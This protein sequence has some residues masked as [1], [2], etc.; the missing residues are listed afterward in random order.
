MQKSNTDVKLD[1]KV[2][3]ESDEIRQACQEAWQIIAPL[4]PLR[5]VIAR[6]PLS[7]LEHMRFEKAVEWAQAHFQK[8]DIAQPLEVINRESIKWFQA[9][10]DA[11]QATITMPKRELGLFHS[12]KLLARYDTHLHQHDPERIAWLQTLPN[13][14][15]FALSRCLHK[16]GITKELYRDFFILLLTTLPGWAGY[17]QYLVAWPDPMQVALF[18][19]S[20]MDFL[21][22]RVVMTSLFWTDCVDYLTKKP[23]DDHVS[24][25]FQLSQTLHKIQHAEDSYRDTLIQAMQQSLQPGEKHAKPTPDA[26]LVFCIDVRSEPLRRALEATGAIE[27]F[28]FA[29]FFGIPVGFENTDTGEKISACPVLL[30]PKHLVQ[31]GSSCG[32]PTGWV[33]RLKACY[34]SLKYNFTTPLS[35]VEVLGPWLGLTMLAR[36]FSITGSARV[37]RWLLKILGASQAHACTSVKTNLA[38]IPLAQQCAYAENA[39][40]MMGLTQRFAPLVV[41]CGHGSTTKNN[42]Q[43]TALDCGAC[44]GQQGGNNAQLLATILNNTQV[45][46]QLHQRGIMIAEHVVFMAAQHNTTTDEVVLFLADNRSDTIAQRISAL[47]Q[48]LVQARIISCQERLAQMSDRYFWQPTPVAQ[49]AQRSVDWAQTRPE[50]GLAR[51]AALIIGP[52]SLT[53]N[54]NL[55]GRAFLHSYDYTLDSNA[56]LLTVILTAPMVVAQWINAQYLFSTLD[57]VAYGA[58]SKITQNITGKIGIMQ[59][60]ASDLMHGLSLQ[61]V[62]QDDTNTCHV[63]QRLLTV[64]YAP[65]QRVMKIIES[66]QVLQTLFGNRWVNLVVIDPNDGRSYLLNADMSWRKIP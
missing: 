14:A 41:F 10:F 59:G 42:P 57:N 64:V 5:N 46:N 3:N 34:Q 2:A 47:Q 52:R 11:G 17:V 1:I 19:V 12:W 20:C 58:G 39:L 23:V 48:A 33:N 28:G 61:S 51:N 55:Q 44:A 62:Y 6:N 13:S 8:S 7:G 37:T 50:W 53:E 66:Q 35:L 60:N 21:A 43:A 65:R 49:L 26:Q 24:H 54:M 30:Q 4:W 56:E 29:G 22:V 63:A 31:V 18:P 16:L 32:K 15:E 38:N 36:T 9:F 45:R 40:S 25:R 27:T